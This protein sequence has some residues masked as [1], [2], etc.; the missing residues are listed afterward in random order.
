[1]LG[2]EKSGNWLS[3]IRNAA[4][5]ALSVTAVNAIQLEDGYISFGAPDA[6]AQ[7]LWVL[8][9]AASDIGDEIARGIRQNMEVRREIAAAPMNSM[10]TLRLSTS[11]L[12]GIVATIAKSGRLNPAE[13]N[14]YCQNVT[15]AVV[16]ILKTPDSLWIRVSYI[17]ATG[18]PRRNGV[19]ILRFGKN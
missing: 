12:D 13:V 7:S 6:Q 17:E 5:G 9:E 11:Q 16:D 10:K 8:P 2:S 3:K 4:V 18:K 19:S 14:A 1:M 15:H